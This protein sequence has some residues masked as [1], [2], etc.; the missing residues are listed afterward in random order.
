VKVVYEF[1]CDK[2]GEEWYEW[3]PMGEALE[4]SPHR[5]ELADGTFGGVTC[6][7]TGRRLLSR[8]NFKAFQGSYLAEVR[9]G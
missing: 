2:C 8:G 6:E 1:K 3:A 4:S 5:A 7:G 9:N